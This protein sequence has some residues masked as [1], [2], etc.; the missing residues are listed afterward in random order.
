MLAYTEPGKP[1]QIWL[2][3]TYSYIWINNGGE[4]SPPVTIRKETAMIDN[5][6]K[7]MDII[8]RTKKLV[9]DLNEKRHQEKLE[10]IMKK[11]EEE[12][13]KLNKIREKTQASSIHR[14]SRSDNADGRD[15]GALSQNQTRDRGEE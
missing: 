3:S 13:N 2:N 1:Y 4:Q 11:Y 5:S 9:D 14:Q 6:I 15:N 7:M 10:E 8:D 12:I